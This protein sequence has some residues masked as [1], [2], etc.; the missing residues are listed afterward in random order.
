MNSNNTI[1][2]Y[3]HDS[4]LGEMS[5]DEANHYRTWAEQ[6]IKNEYPTHN[7]RVANE[8]ATTTCWTND[9]DNAEEIVD[10]VSSLWDNYS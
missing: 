4:S 8:P 7:V 9:D 3:A 2:Y 1:I 10:F 5:I 6:S